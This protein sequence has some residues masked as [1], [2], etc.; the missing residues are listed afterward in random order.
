MRLPPWLKLVLVVA[1]LILAGYLL[2]L[3]IF[4]PKPVPV[5][6][7]RVAPGTVE[8]T[9]TNSKAGTVKVRRRSKMSPEVGGRVAYIGA[10]AGDRITKG[11]VLLRIN[12]ADLKA[13]LALAQHDL[14]TARA[15]AQEACL[16][17]DLAER[18]YQRSLGLKKDQIV[19]TEM[20]DRLESGSAAAGARCAAARAAIERSSAAIDLAEA[21]L[22]KTA[23]LA[24]FDGVVADLR[25]EMGEWA[26][27]SPPGMALPP[28][29]DLIDPTSIYVSAPLD[30]VDAGKVRVGLSAR[31]TLDPYPGKSFTGRVTR[32]A[33]YVLDVEQQNRTLEVE[34]D[35]DGAD[36][37]RT[38]LPGTSADV[39]IIL[40]A[41]RD[42][43]RI[44]S[45]ALL[46]GDRALVFEQGLLAEREVK[47]GL[48]NWEYAE[49]TNGLRKDDLV[50]VSLD[51]AEV[52]AGARAVVKTEQKE[53]AA[54][55]DQKGAGKSQAGGQEDPKDT[56][57]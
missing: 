37:A 3:T 6:V 4:R 18:D 55:D 44:P 30:E 21:N 14:A 53:A 11:E 16:A 52:K 47:T 27:P 35:F 15:T 17:A 32:V 40:K 26:S 23:L 1:A 49:V 20:L 9:V 29:Y 24:P 8:E 2:R 54:K 28:V 57:R 34:I 22:K 51:R 43:L 7:F 10:R 12:D 50:V 41:V 38:L 5:T 42:V 25:T 36:F 46:E 13:A 56:A 45:Y 33:P 31:I 39:E 48:R 19:S